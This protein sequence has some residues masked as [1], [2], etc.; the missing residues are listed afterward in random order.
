VSGD[1]LDRVLADDYLEGLDERPPHE[2]RAMRVECEAQEDG[3]SY[4]RRILQGRI[5]LLRSEVERREQ[6]GEVEGEILA[7]LPTVLS[8]QGSAPFDPA[9]VR[10]PRRLV[11]PDTE[12]GPL[13]SGDALDL[14]RRSLD[15]LRDMA[16]RYAA[17]EGELSA[18]RRRLFAVIDRLQDELAERYR[19]G[20]A[21][22]SDLLADDA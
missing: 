7:A 1:E 19:S 9:R 2:V 21:D 5:D 12:A 6:G 22:V 20:D 17:H 16:E 4:A 10:L 18:I 8:D 11:P 14:D 13:D 15:E 3:V